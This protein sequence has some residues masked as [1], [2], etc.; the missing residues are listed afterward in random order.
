MITIAKS[1]RKLQSPNTIVKTIKILYL[2]ACD[3]FKMLVGKEH[4][5]L[6]EV[7]ETRIQVND[8]LKILKVQI[9]KLVTIHYIK[10]RAKG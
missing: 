4:G 5:T 8:E 9:H 3:T 10:S 6:A 2:L 7:P 1:E